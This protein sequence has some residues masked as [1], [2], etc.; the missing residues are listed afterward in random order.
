MSN[1]VQEVAEAAYVSDRLQ[2]AGKP[3]PPQITNFLHDA[4]ARARLLPPAALAAAEHYLAAAK[5]DIGRR[6]SDRE[7]NEM[8]SYADQLYKSVTVGV[9]GSVKGLSRE[10]IQRVA[11][12]KAVR[13]KVYG[14][15]PMAL[16]RAERPARREIVK[17][18]DSD[19]R[20]A[21]LVLAVGDAEADA[22]SRARTPQEL[23]GTVLSDWQ[24][25]QILE[26]KGLSGDIARAWDAVEARDANEQMIERAAALGNRDTE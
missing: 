10:E 14:P 15:S 5:V 20:R 13:E 8:R 17:P 3:V 24:H 23:A 6:E 9:A 2:A 1:F 19:R 25:P 21:A 11:D 18:T 16:N 7:A 22:I 26:E 4:M 12:G